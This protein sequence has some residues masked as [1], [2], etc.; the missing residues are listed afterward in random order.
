MYMAA[1]SV[2]LHFKNILLLLVAILEY[3]APNFVLRKRKRS[4]KGNAYQRYTIRCLNIRSMIWDDDIECVD[5]I[6]MDRRA[7]YKLCNMVESIGL[8]WST[9]N[10][11]IEEMLASF[12]YI[13]AHNTKNRVAKRE[14]VRSGETISRHFNSVLLAILRLH[15]VLLKKPEPVLQN[16]RAHPWKW[17]KNCLGALDG[18]YIK[19]NVAEQDKPKYRTRKGDLATN[20]LGVC[21]QDLNFIYI[22][23]GWEG[24]A[25]DARVLRSAVSRSNGFLVPQGYYYLCDA[26]YSNAD[27]FLAPYRGQRYHLKEW[28]QNN[29]PRTKEEMFNYKHS[30]ARNVIERSFGLLK[31]RWAILRERSWYPIKTHCRV[32]TACALLHNHIR[33]EMRRDPLEDK[34]PEDYVDPDTL[35]NV[36]NIQDIEPSVAWTAYHLEII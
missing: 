10:T 9:K 21:S 27:G 29:Q 25:A 1:Y 20:V 36:P 15:E 33:R 31:M 14:F 32:I 19:L 11:S 16:C 23:P 7:F 35:L 18:T 4:Q 13:L 30:S 28:S 6:R 26:G 8:L 2:M 34:V 24:S 3:Y 5:N 17:F 12:L 22:L